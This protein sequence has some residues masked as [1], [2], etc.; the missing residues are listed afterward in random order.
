MIAG[1]H[2]NSRRCANDLVSVISGF[3][4]AVYLQYSLWIPSSFTRHAHISLIIYSIL[5]SA[6]VQ[7]PGCSSLR[8]C[9]GSP[10]AC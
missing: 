5:F 6:K 4:C 3:V 9:W 1:D 8:A 10:G 2:L 7:S